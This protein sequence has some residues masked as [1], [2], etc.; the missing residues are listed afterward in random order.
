MVRY[1][2][3]WRRR[4]SPI[5]KRRAEPSARRADRCTTAAEVLDWHPLS[6]DIEPIRRLV[7]DLAE[8]ETLAP[9]TGRIVPWYSMYPVPSYVPGTSQRAY[10][11]PEYGIDS[12]LT[13]TVSLE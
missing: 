3:R 9:E 7:G 1:Y 12:S 2:D 5:L 10:F 11:T 6:A 8:L 4:R 13:P